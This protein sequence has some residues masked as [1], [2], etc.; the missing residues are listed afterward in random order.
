MRS[1]IVEWS[2]VA[3]TH[4]LP[5]RYV[6]EVI[7]EDPVQVGEICDIASGA[8]VEEYIARDSTGSVP[9]LRVNNVREFVP[10]VSP[11]DVQYVAPRRG[12][13]DR[14]CVAAGDVIIARTGTLGRAFVAPS[15]LNKAVMSQH[16]TRLRLRKQIPGCAQ[17]LA[18]YLNSPQGK[19]QVMAVA[20]G[21]TRL[22]LTHDDINRLLIPRSI[23]VGGR[24]T[25][26]AGGIERDF[27]NAIGGAVAAIAA[28]DRL[29]PATD[30]QEKFFAVEYD[31]ALFAKSLA[32]RYHRPSGARLE[33]FLKENFECV[34]LGQLAL[35]KRGAGSLAAEYEPEGIPYI[36]TSSIVNYG[37]ELFPEHYGTEDTYRA[38]RQ[39]VG[40]GD[41]L[42][43]MEGKVGAIAFLGEQERCLIKNHVEFIRL[44]RTSPVPA[45]FVYALLTSHVG[46]TQIKRRTVVQATIP[47]LG[48]ESRNILIPVAGR[49]AKA[50]ALFK[51]T[52]TEVTREVRL[53]QDARSRLRTR[54]RDL[55]DAVRQPQPN[56][57]PTGEAA[58]KMHSHLASSFS[59]P[60]SRGV[61][62]PRPS[63]LP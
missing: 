32:P 46:Q 36:R 2:R 54:L 31:D 16:V 19:A 33:A 35:V 11:C 26:M 12:W 50:K 57:H 52:L 4:L 9:Y 25:E 30:A 1:A 28:C 15:V 38:H 42:L 55:V 39:S 14:E 37:I 62:Q 44:H 48:S 60:S 56:R 21:S 7:V 41:I 5:K 59:K 34:P 53:S 13:G 10:N 47:G 6:D 61:Q 24:L 17:L 45:E 63:S 18:A 20:S 3:G 8:Y 27:E 29:A 51:E 40:P 23:V 49:N 43:T 58:K 22:E